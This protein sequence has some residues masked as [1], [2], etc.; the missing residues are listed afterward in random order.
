MLAGAPCSACVGAAAWEMSLMRQIQGVIRWLR[1]FLAA[2]AALWQ[3][4]KP[5]KRTH[6]FQ[7]A[8]SL[9]RMKQDALR[10]KRK[11]LSGRCGAYLQRQ[12]RCGSCTS[13]TSAP[14]ASRKLTA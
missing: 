6:R 12:Q 1:R 14:I 11:V 8:H 4:K 3:L 7:K 9:E 13:P 2:P 10:A 5:D